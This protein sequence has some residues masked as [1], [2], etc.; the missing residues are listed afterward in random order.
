MLLKTIIIAVLL[1]GFIFLAL[2]IKLITGKSKE[3]KLHTC[4]YEQVPGGENIQCDNCGLKDLTQ[5]NENDRN[6][7]HLKN[8]TT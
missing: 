3:A 5:C 6:E 7:A 8:Q 2:G 4:A 1:L